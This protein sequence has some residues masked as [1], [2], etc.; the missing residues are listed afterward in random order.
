MEK[1]DPDPPSL[2]HVVTINGNSI[3]CLPSYPIGR[4]YL[5][6][7]YPH[8]GYVPHPISKWATR[9]QSHSL[10]PGYKSRLRTPVQHQ[11]SLELG[12]LSSSFEFS[13]SNSISHSNKLY[14]PLIVSYVWK[15]FSNLRP[16]HDNTALMKEIEEDTNR[17]KP[18]CACGLE[19]LMLKCPH[20]PQQSTKSMQ[21]LSFF[22]KIEWNHKRPWVVKVILRKKNKA[23][24]ILLSDFK[25]ITK[26]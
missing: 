8:P 14:F 26:V 22:T 5:P 15:F 12:K 6:Y 10:Y 21:S 23:E 1:P 11:F 18:F 3:T 20:Y 7:S 9:P 2:P 25:H 16:E 17:G 19:E 13:L 24:G 4:R